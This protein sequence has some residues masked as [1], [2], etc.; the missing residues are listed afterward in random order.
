MDCTGFERRGHAVRS[1]ESAMQHSLNTHP[2][3]SLVLG[4]SCSS[5]NS[6]MACRPLPAHPALAHPSRPPHRWH[7]TLTA[8]HRRAVH[9][10][11]AQQQPEKEVGGYAQWAEMDDNL[12]VYEPEEYDDEEE[13]EMVDVEQDDGT[14]RRV[15]MEYVLLFFQVG[16]FFGG[17][18]WVNVRMCDAATSCMQHHHFAT[19]RWSSAHHVTQHI[20]NIHTTPLP[21]TL[22]SSQSPPHHTP[23]TPLITPP[24]PPSHPHNPHPTTVWWSTNT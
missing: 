14:I 11:V 4:P 22:F 19:Q 5:R 13:E 10:R 6:S 18:F 7:P 17:V 23:T 8:P 15:P 3:H 9:A 2:R 24:Q 1:S 21:I 20:S 12:Y 16:V